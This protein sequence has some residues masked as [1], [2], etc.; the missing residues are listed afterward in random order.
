MRGPDEKW[1]SFC[2]N[3][4]ISFYFSNKM[5]FK[6][7]QI[8][9]KNTTLPKF[10]KSD[11]GQRKYI[12]KHKS[13]HPNEKRLCLEEIMVNCDVIC[14]GD[15]KMEWCAVPPTLHSNSWTLFIEVTGKLFSGDIL[16][17]IILEPEKVLE[18]KVSK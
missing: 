3:S 14:G 9:L 10:K 5:H 17:R 2:V 8:T 4:K 15:E 13:I 16:F 12:W 1:V 7:N 18:N 11:G 6:Q